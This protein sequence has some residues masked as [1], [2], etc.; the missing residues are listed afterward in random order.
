MFHQP[1]K[2]PVKKPKP[3]S[4]VTQGPGQ[5]TRRGEIQTQNKRTTSNPRSGNAITQ[6]RP[7]TASS[8]QHPSPGR[9]GARRGVS[10]VGKGRPSSGYDS[11]RVPSS[12]E[13]NVHSPTTPHGTPVH[14][15]PPKRTNYSSELSAY[16]QYVRQSPAESRTLGYHP[17]NDLVPPS[18]EYDQVMGRQSG[19]R[20]NVPPST[21]NTQPYD[22]SSVLM[23]QSSQQSRQVPGTGKTQPSPYS[24]RMRQE[25]EQELNLKSESN[26]I[27][28]NSIGRSQNFT[29]QT[30]RS[31]Q[32]FPRQ[33]PS[34]AYQQIPQSS[35]Y[36][37]IP[38]TQ[39]GY[40]ASA[41]SPDVSTYNRG[42]GD[43]WSSSGKMQ[44]SQEKMDE[45]V[46]FLV[47]TNITL[48][49]RVSK[50]E[51]DIE[52]ERQNR[53]LLEQRIRT[54][55]IQGRDRI[56]SLPQEP[57]DFTEIR[58]R[59]TELESK[60]SEVGNRMRKYEKDDHGTKDDLKNLSGIVS[61]LRDD[62]LS[63]GVG[64]RTTSRPSA[65]GEDSRPKK[66]EK[67]SSHLEDSSSDDSDS[68]EDHIPNGTSKFSDSIRTPS[69]TNS[70]GRVGS[71]YSPS[72]SGKG[73]SS[74]ND[75]LDRP[76]VPTQTL[77]P[78]SSKPFEMASSS[79]STFATTQP[80]P[81][82]AQIFPITADR[83]T[84]SG[85]LTNF[86][87]R[88]AYEHPAST[89][90]ITQT[91]DT[92]YHPQQSRNSK[93][94]EDSESSEDSDESSSEG[95]GSFHLS[96]S[97][98]KRTPYASTTGGQTDSESS[99]ESDSSEYEDEKEWV[100]RIPSSFNRQNPQ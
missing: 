55:D 82:R 88:Q 2:A 37:S 30:N 52:D 90:P 27:L 100:N 28:M 87:Y 92:S 72:S 38:S 89:G 65:Y 83:E 81:P 9:Q 32:Q 20:F 13:T 3:T 50:L 91:R 67:P 95:R 33:Q 29:S 24:G 16:Q 75:L 7:K 54:L 63:V 40:R 59:L 34:Q 86:Q 61:S 31:P 66:Y 11:K 99:S 97:E 76:Y 77:P 18:S 35:G 51:R 47:E 62:I 85:D 25:L 17:T 84:G 94:S 8:V 6:S 93:D 70:G 4:K 39:D 49:N 58:D 98:K 44:Q 71:H 48:L 36:R 96:N 22:Y 79:H 41:T 23:S 53:I 57:Q 14:S 60:I 73:I 64:S 80:S 26:D 19:G 42:P 46:R 12:N 78:P 10:P 15:S 43:G 74:G 68:S 21:F 45:N 69:L 1:S 5:V 56:G